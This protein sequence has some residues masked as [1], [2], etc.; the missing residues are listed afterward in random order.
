M[1][2]CHT[3]LYEGLLAPIPHAFDERL[4]QMRPGMADGT[5][6][7]RDGMI[8]GDGSTREGERCTARTTQGRKNCGRQHVPL[9]R[10]DRSAPA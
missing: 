2:W 9:A 7:I 3:D 8:Q 5:A 1:A 6:E 4:P 10:R